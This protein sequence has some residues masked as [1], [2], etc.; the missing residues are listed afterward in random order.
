MFVWKSDS[1]HVWGYRY[2]CYH[3]FYELFFPAASLAYYIAAIK[4]KG[5][6]Q[7]LCDYL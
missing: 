2:H 7:R 1:K 6:N 3:Y 4:E 5:W